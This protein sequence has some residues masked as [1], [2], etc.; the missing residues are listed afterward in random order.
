MTT[1][2][3]KQAVLDASKQAF[4][5]G[6]FAGTSGNLSLRDPQTGLIAITPSSVSYDA[7]TPDDVVLLAPDGAVV[8]CLPTRRPS[9]EWRMHQT[10]Y[11]HRRDLGAV[12]H[13]HSPSATAFAV[14]GEAI[15]AILIEMIFFLY[16]SV[17]VAPYQPPGSEALGLSALS[18]LAGRT[19][20]LLAHHGVLAIG[21]DLDA[22]LLCAVYTEDA[23]KI[24]S[25]S[26]MIRRVRPL[27]AEAQ[28]EIRRRMGLPE[29]E[30]A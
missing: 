26:Q 16:G 4:A 1:R 13:T 3:M 22:A 8:E 6:L 10:L 27:S 5:Q 11:A 7:M 24:C 12:V 28:N 30:D 29:E 21:P 19:A 14:A 2:E 15:P 17:R 18:A 25:I 23:A 9:S 20:C